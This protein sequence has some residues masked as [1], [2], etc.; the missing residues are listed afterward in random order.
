MAETQ[1]RYIGG[2]RGRIPG[3]VAALVAADLMEYEEG[4]L[5]FVHHRVRAH[6][7]ERAEAEHG[8]T[9]GALV[10]TRMLSSVPGQ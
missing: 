4:A 3:A 7:R 1:L 8:E 9:E 6:A 2:A 10:F 5:R